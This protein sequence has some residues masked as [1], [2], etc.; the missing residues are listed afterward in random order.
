MHDFHV[1]QCYMWGLIGDTNT[2]LY[3]NGHL[4]LNV[5]IPVGSLWDFCFP[6]GPRSSGVKH[7]LKFAQLSRMRTILLKLHTLI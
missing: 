7:D 2:K 1:T 3:S 5:S 6:S 4:F